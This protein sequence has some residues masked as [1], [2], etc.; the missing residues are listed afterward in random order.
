MFQIILALSIVTALSVILIILRKGN[1]AI[2]AGV[3]V[4][5]GILLVCSIVMSILGFNP[6]NLDKGLIYKGK[7]GNDEKT[8]TVENT[9]KKLSGY[10]DI[11]RYLLKAGMAEDARK[12]LEEYSEGAEY[13]IEYI[14]IYAEIDKAIGN[15]EHAETMTDLFN[16]SDFKIEDKDTKLDKDAEKAAKAYVAINQING[17]E[18]YYEDKDELNKCIN[19]WIDA[20]CPYSD[21][22]TMNRGMI[23]AYAYT[24]DYE[25]IMDLIFADVNNSDALITSANLIKYDVVDSDNADIVSMKKDMKIVIG[26]L[27]D[28]MYDSSLSDKDVQILEEAVDE[29]NKKIDDDDEVLLNYIVERMRKVVDEDEINA[30]KVYLE[31]AEIAYEKG[32]EDNTKLYIDKAIEYGQLSDDADFGSAAKKIS[33]IIKDSS[34]PEKRKSLSED[35]NEFV[36]NRF[37]ENIPIGNIIDGNTDNYNS[38]K[39]NENSDDDNYY[40]DGDYDS[41]YDDDDDYDNN[42]DYDDDDD[43]DDVD[44]GYGYDDYDSKNDYNS[45]EDDDSDASSDKK[46]YKP[47][48]SAESQD[49]LKDELNE[50]INQMVGSI[51]IV[52]VDTSNFKTESPVITSVVAVDDT[53]VSDAEDFKKCINLTD[54]NAEITD[55]EV[56]KIEYSEI[57]IVLVC[58]DSGSMSGTP[59]DDLCAAIK[60][61]AEKTNTGINI[62]VVPFESGVNDSSVAAIGS[63]KEEI[64]KTADSLSASGGT[65]ILGAVE[66]AT[67]MFTEGDDELNV[68]ILMSDG[69]DEYPEAE[70]MEELQA[71]WLSRGIT[72][73]TVGLGDGVDAELLTEYSDYG[74]G[75]YFYVN[76]SESI[77]SFYNFIYNT[78]KNKYRIKYNAIDTFTVDR[79][80]QLTYKDSIN[81]SDWKDYS[82]YE[83]DL[84]SLLAKGDFDITITNGDNVVQINGL[85]K[86]MIYPC[87]TDQI[88]KLKGSG[89]NKD[90]KL[91]FTIKSVSEYTCTAK[92][93][94]ENTYDITIPANIATG[95]YDLYIKY[96]GAQRVIANGL[97][98]ASNNVNI[99]KYGDYVFTASNAT[100][101]DNSVTMSGVVSL[102]DWLYFSDPVSLTGNLETDQE[103]T[104]DFGKLFVPFMD[105]DK[106]GLSGVFARN[107][108]IENLPGNASVKLYNDITADSSED[109]YPVE[110]ILAENCRVIDLMTISLNEAGYSIYPDRAVVNFNEFTTELP[111]QK[112]LI[113]DKVGDFFHFTADKDLKLTYSKDTID[114][115]AKLEVENSDT[116]DDEFRTLKLGNSNVYYIPGSVEIEL[117]TKKGDYKIGASTKV[118]Y[119]IDDIG[120]EIAAEDNKLNKIEL[121]LDLGDKKNPTV[122]VSGVP[123]T[124]S[125]F[126]LSIDDM[127][128]E[129]N[130]FT[131]TK[132][133]EKIASSELSGSTKISVAKL[134][135]VFP[136][137]KD[138][139]DDVCIISFDETKI[140]LK[141]IDPYIKVSTKA[142]VFDKVEVAD[143][144]LQLG[145]DLDYSNP[146]LVIQ[147]D[148]D[149][150]VGEIGV[151]IKFDIEPNLSVDIGGDVNLALT[152]Q[153]LGLTTKGNI[154]LMAKF[155]DI[156]M[157]D[158]NVSGTA[159]IGA[160]RQSNEEMAFTIKYKSSGDNIVHEIICTGSDKAYSSNTY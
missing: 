16:D 68:V 152:N 118:A 115:Y 144:N 6:D 156:V 99:I 44:D 82:L 123:V 60:K 2:W 142:K 97:I 26:Y 105:E 27:N 63:S 5:M 104:M 136:V 151:G 120:F 149:G 61:F 77:D 146:L 1:R 28:A 122:N 95:I 14:S 15:T 159:F 20:G 143:A 21:I 36:D 8:K 29:L 30:G 54:T 137:I 86:Q 113:D 92:Y 9:S 59:R 75:S 148:V 106:S 17:G 10:L 154:Y 158:K 48:S 112:K 91:E 130:D 37:P 109:D 50:S 31:L 84:S 90:K 133:L 32:D 24:N 150:F 127:E 102:N 126:A 4:C 41:N 107:G 58:D 70:V 134:G 85:N 119:L 49:I 98:V 145:A 46:G 155:W 100:R 65:N 67:G 81:I 108:I 96:D 74:G 138:Y 3:S 76:S 40:D 53:L 88:L 139:I 7:N 34:D 117:D 22:P 103:V 62:G 69:Q 78:S 55:Y 140:S 25:G 19:D 93:V 83:D 157:A 23:G 18:V 94:D 52:S 87:T 132:W 129:L 73:Y 147:D 11:A 42:L 125:D 114:F 13:N 80:L 47:S 72:V 71:N 57:N 33:D 135:E 131:N 124:I 56:E 39:D 79:Y 12:I 111:F 45:D 116:D 51:N 153:V 128:L 101:G 110:P 35:I 38:N 121:L 160:Y 89:F 66:Y 64:I 43:Y 141:F